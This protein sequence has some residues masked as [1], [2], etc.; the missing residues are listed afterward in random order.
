MTCQQPDTENSRAKTTS[1]EPETDQQSEWEDLSDDEPTDE[2]ILCNEHDHA[3][4]VQHQITLQKL[5]GSLEDI[6]GDGSHCNDLLSLIP[7]SKLHQTTSTSEQ[8]IASSSPARRV[9]TDNKAILEAFILR[10]KKPKKRLSATAKLESVENKRHSGAIR[11]A[12]TSPARAQILAELDANSPLPAQT[13]SPSSKAAV[14]PIGGLNL[15]ENSA[16]TRPETTRRSARSKRRAQQEDDDLQ[17]QQPEPAKISFRGTARQMPLTTT[18]SRSVN[19]I[20]RSNTRKNTA[21]AVPVKKRLSML[22]LDTDGNPVEV[23]IANNKAREDAKAVGWNSTLV[24]YQ[25]GTSLVDDGRDGGDAT[26][27][28]P[29]ASLVTPRARR[30]RA[31][32]IH[33]YAH[34]VDLAA[35]EASIESE[36]QSAD[37]IGTKGAQEPET[38]NGQEPKELGLPKQ[39]TK[40]RSRI[41]SRI[42]TPAKGLSSRAGGTPISAPIQSTSTK[43]KGGQ[44]RRHKPAATLTAPGVPTAR[45]ID[46]EKPEHIEPATDMRDSTQDNSEAPASAAGPSTP[47]KPEPQSAFAR[48]ISLQQSQQQQQMPVVAPATMAPPTTTPAPNLSSPAKRRPRLENAIP[49]PSTS[50]IAAVRML[51]SPAKR[52]AKRPDLDLPVVEAAAGGGG[53]TTSPLPPPLPPSAPVAMLLSPAKRRPVRGNAGLRSMARFG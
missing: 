2:G 35:A 5:F 49:A 40:G 24:F 11:L 30:A 51:Q 6:A 18:D 15:A 23:D 45:K 52:P 25:D 36:P 38:D 20:T 46:F 39:T 7:S 43:A 50:A 3:T 4:T 26:A 47:E 44:S 22:A 42:A 34:A 27:A 13:L 12:M 29:T 17:A 1:A 41:A 21:E 28:E 53:C 48:K 14:A 33:A 10:A 37:A 8:H 31:R 9:S 32:K 16:A 19:V